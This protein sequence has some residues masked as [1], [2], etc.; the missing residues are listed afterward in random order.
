MSHYYYPLNKPSQTMTVNSQPEKQLNQ[1]YQNSSQD[2]FA[3][4]HCSIEFN[5]NEHLLMKIQQTHKENSL[6]QPY[7][8]QGHHREYE[9]TPNK[10]VNS[11]HHQRTLSDYQINL[12]ASSH[13]PS[14]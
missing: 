11:H 12:I 2:K 3:F 10:M 13:Q 14:K 6:K 8:I 4:K 5:K 7:E 9:K 1:S